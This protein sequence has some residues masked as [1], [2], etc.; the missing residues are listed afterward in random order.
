MGHLL[1]VVVY[2]ACIQSSYDTQDSQKNAVLNMTTYNDDIDDI[3][4]EL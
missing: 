3:I 4:L 1:Y 2:K